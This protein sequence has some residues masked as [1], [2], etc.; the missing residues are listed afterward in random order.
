MRTLLVGGGGIG[1]VVGK[2]ISP[3]SLS[4]ASTSIALPGVGVRDPARMIP[5]SLVLLVLLCILS[6]LM[7]D[8]G[9][10]LAAPVNVHPPR[11][12]LR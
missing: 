7:M 9:P 6:G 4:V 1:G 12:S 2:M 10:Q 5:W 8:P 11:R 3:Q